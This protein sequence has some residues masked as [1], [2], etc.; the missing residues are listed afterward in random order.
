MSKIV[1]LLS[2]LSI[3]TI[4]FNFRY[5]PFKTAIKFPIL[6]S[7]NVHILKSKGEIV[8]EG[9]ISTGLIQIGYGSV[10]IFDK[11][12]SRSLW[13]VSGKVVFKGK[14]RIGHGSKISVASGGVLT[15]GNNFNITAE[16]SIYCST[17]VVFGD[18]CLLSWDILII[19]TDFHKIYNLNNEIINEP[20]PIYIGNKVWINCRCLILK[21][22]KIGENSIIGASSIVS[23]QLEG[24]GAIYAGSPAKKIKE[25]IK[26]EI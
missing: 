19:D 9:E 7:K 4:V 15:F 12:K 23:G 24:G 13:E 3:N 11:A 10:G 17:E 8:I 6:I 20:K 26:W 21:G 1:K 16:S 14:T 25:D 2:R 22:A 18:D 5:F